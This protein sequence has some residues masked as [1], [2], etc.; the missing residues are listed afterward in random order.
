MGREKL[1]MA[2]TPDVPLLD[3][4]R[5]IGP[6]FYITPTEAPCSL[7]L[8]ALK[9][10]L[11]LSLQ[12]PALNFLQEPKE[13]WF[14]DATAT[15][16]ERPVQEGGRDTERPAGR[17]Q[18]LLAQLLRRVRARPPGQQYRGP[19]LPPRAEADVGGSLGFGEEGV[20]GG[21]SLKGRV[22]VRWAMRRGG[23]L[24]TGKKSWVK[25]SMS[26]TITRAVFTGCFWM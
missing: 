7:R 18:G 5:V 10:N 11:L 20:G 22:V 24:G 21:H 6:G 14:T 23:G 9:K 12:A 17:P 19:E 26:D 2:M 8:F 4:S 13:V 16:A 1:L 15:P 25:M 3:I